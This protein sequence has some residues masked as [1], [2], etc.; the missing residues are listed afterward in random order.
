[1][2]ILYTVGWVD[3]VLIKNIDKWKNYL[4]LFK[5]NAKVLDQLE[6]AYLPVKTHPKKLEKEKIVACQTLPNHKP[7]CALYALH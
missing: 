7:M 4:K 2:T 3:V 5:K 1:M 6:N